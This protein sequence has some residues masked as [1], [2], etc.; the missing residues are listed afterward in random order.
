MIYFLYCGGSVKER[1]KNDENWKVK[2]SNGQ[3]GGK[4]KNLFA[5]LK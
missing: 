3:E 5:S 4:Q 1:E 2:V